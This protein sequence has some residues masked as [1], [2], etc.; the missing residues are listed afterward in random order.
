MYGL[1]GFSSRSVR[2]EFFYWKNENMFAYSKNSRTFAA[3]LR[4]QSSWRGGR[5]VD[6]GGLENRWTERFPGFESLSLRQQGAVSWCQLTALVLYICVCLKGSC[7]NC[8]V[9]R[10]RGQSEKY[11]AKRVPK[12]YR[13]FYNVIIGWFHTKCKG[14]Q[15][16]N[17]IDNMN[18]DTQTSQL[19]GR[20]VIIPDKKGFSDGHS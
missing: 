12:A 20:I 4:K 14:T 16:D 2:K 10:Y 6:C 8:R 18:V 19:R 15:D 9:C 13:P 5:V 11:V 3:L 17:R 7:R 1:P